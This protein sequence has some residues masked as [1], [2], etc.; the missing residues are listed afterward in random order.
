MLPLKDSV[1]YTLQ[2]QVWQHQKV[3]SEQVLAGMQVNSPS[4]VQKTDIFSQMPIFKGLAFYYFLIN[5]DP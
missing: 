2:E 3:T 4:W 1:V 5:L